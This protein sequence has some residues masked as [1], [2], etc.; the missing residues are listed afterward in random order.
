M[1]TNLDA[2][3]RAFRKY[4]P[5]N[6]R[7][8]ALQISNVIKALE[9]SLNKELVV[10]F[11]GARM[12][13]VE[14]NTGATSGR[15]LTDLVSDIIIYFNRFDIKKFGKSSDP[16][17]MYVPKHTIS[18]WFSFKNENTL[19]NLKVRMGGRSL[20]NAWVNHSGYRFFGDGWESACKI[21]RTI[22]NELHYDYATMGSY[23]SSDIREE[24]FDDWLLNCTYFSK[25]GNYTIPPGMPDVE[26]EETAK[27][28]YLSIGNKLCTSTDD[29]EY[30]EQK[31][32]RLEATRRI[33]QAN[34]LS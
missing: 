3:F 8:Y 15:D 21:F 6:I 7:S 5:Q 31:Q 22:L 11:E 9:K 30:Q 32:T 29:P 4:E 12:R 1:S 10:I 20:P 24:K 27:G 25:N 18:V 13:P 28:V 34:G 33:K 19:V 17:S 2:V 23:S 26:Y 16:D 14:I